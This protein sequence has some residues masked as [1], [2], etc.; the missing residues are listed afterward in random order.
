[1]MATMAERESGKEH[2]DGHRI[3]GSETCL[4]LMKQ[5]V[6]QPRGTCSHVPKQPNPSE[7]K[8]LYLGQSPVNPS[9]ICEFDPV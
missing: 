6:Y 7:V 3:E 1:M 9:S 2:G 4:S 8:P 5:A